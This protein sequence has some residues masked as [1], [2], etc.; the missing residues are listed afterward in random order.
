MSDECRE[1]NFGQCFRREVIVLLKKSVR[2]TGVSIRHKTPVDRTDFFKRTRGDTL[3]ISFSNGFGV[4]GIPG[5]ICSKDY[6]A[7]AA[8]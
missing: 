2:S 3:F 5:L 1:R 7:V 4:C 8:A 6:D